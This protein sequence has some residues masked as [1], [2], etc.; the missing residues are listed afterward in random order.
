[1]I[2]SGDDVSRTAKRVSILCIKWW[3]ISLMMAVMVLL[4]DGFWVNLFRNITKLTRWMAQSYRK[5]ENKEIR[6]D[7]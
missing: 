4:S 5:G 3:K 2:I 7:K 6:L 1:L